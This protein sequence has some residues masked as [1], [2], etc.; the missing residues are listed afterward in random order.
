MYCRFCSAHVGY[1]KTHDC[2]KAGPLDH[3]DN[4]KVSELS[5]EEKLKPSHFCHHPYSSVTFEAHHEIVAHNIM[6]VL[7]N[8]GDQWR[9]LTWEEYRDHRK[10]KGVGTWVFGEGEKRYFDRVIGY[11]TSADKAKNF[12]PSW[13]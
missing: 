12:S 7:S 4:F 2:P 6:I 13:K 8:T 9:S 3:S 1:S 10:K 5:T 11:C